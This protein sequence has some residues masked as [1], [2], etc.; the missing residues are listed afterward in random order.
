MMPARRPRLFV[1]LDGVLADFDGGFPRIF[2]WDHRDG[3][4]SE[5][6]KAIGTRP[7][8]FNELHPFPGAVAFFHAI[9]PLVAGILT[10]ASSSYYLT[11]AAAKHRWVRRNLCEDVLVLPVSDGLHKPAFIQDPGDVLVDD[12]GKNCEA[13]QAAGGGAI[14]HE[15]GDFPRTLKMIEAV[16]G[17]ASDW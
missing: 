7:D 9:R 13:W 4:K 11:A 15:P 14:K 5:M 10:S 17:P 1:D 2:G 12:W 16:F 6:W 3:P 8:F